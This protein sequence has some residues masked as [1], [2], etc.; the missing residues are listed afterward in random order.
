VTEPWSER[1]LLVTGLVA[2]AVNLRSAITSLGAVLP[3]VTRTWG[4]SG[5]VAGILT[6]LPV[7]TFAV[8][9][10]A[11]PALARRL[12]PERAVSAAMLVAAVGLVLRA[13]SGSVTCSSPPPAAR[14]PARRWATC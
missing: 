3:E 1:A 4:M 8:V 12:G 7:A 10:A 14:W 13:V 2:V 5:L 9:G 11:T 6:A